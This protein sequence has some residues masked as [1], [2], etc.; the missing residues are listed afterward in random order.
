MGL[1]GG[2]PD[3]DSISDT[4]QPELNPKLLLLRAWQ[5][6]RLQRTHADLLA[7]KRYGPACR[8]FIS[9]VYGS[10]DFHQ[11]NQ[12]IEYMYVIMRRFIPDL[13][14]SLVR[15]AINLHH[16]TE[17]LDKKLLK[18]LGQDLGLTD[19][20]SEEM[21]AEGYRLCDNYDNRRRQID[22]LIEIGHQVEFSTRLPPIGIALRLAGG[23]A[24]KAGWQDLHDFLDRG[25]KSFKKMGKAKKFLNTVQRREMLI[26]DRIYDGLPDPFSI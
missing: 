1:L 6:E 19:N 5:T 17:E 18:V 3:H 13:L 9:D 2:L 20:I 8:F 4:D 15:N 10:K 23:P 7:S 26:L 21:Y 16:M 12:D 14:L 22:M 24:K 11:R 25:Y